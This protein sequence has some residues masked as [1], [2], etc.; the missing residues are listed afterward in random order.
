MNAPTETPRCDRCPTAAAKHL[1]IRG[2]QD[3]QWCNHHARA[4][5]DTLMAAGFVHYE[6]AVPDVQP[7]GTSAVA[8]S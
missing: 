1:Y 3:W 2:D 8:R 7:V 5:H 4:Y 6:L